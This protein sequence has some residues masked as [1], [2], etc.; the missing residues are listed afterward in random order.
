MDAG[1]SV[2]GRSGQD[3]RLEK[4]TKTGKL[5]TGFATRGIIALAGPSVAVV[6]EQDFDAKTRIT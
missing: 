6:I 5:K 2:R 3:A 4:D 1:R